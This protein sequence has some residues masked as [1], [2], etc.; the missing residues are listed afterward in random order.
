MRELRKSYRGITLTKIDSFTERGLKQVFRA[1]LQTIMGSEHPTTNDKKDWPMILQQ[2]YKEQTDIGWTQVLFGRLS[3]KWAEANAQLKGQ[4]EDDKPYWSTRTINLCW[5]FGL[6]VWKARN[7]LV[8]KKKGGVSK[9][10]YTE[11]QKLIQAL[12]ERMKPQVAAQEGGIFEIPLAD[13]LNSTYTVQTAWLECVQQLHQEQYH[14][15]A[16]EIR[17]KAQ[18]ESELE[19]IKLHGTF[20]AE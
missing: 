9:L 2:V 17:G 8:H 12:Y 20:L 5:N 10:I 19:L 1:G 11:N 4:R 18:T 7:S 14:A 6:E 13:R 3:K 16:Q 15:I